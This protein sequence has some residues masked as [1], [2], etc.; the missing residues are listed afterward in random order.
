MLLWESTD[1]EMNM[2]D[3]Y[4]ICFPQFIQYMY[5]FIKS[6]AVWR[7]QDGYVGK[8]AASD[9]SATRTQCHST[10]FILVKSCAN[11]TRLLHN[12]HTPQFGVLPVYA[13]D[14]AYSG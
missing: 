8:S 10:V 14:V 1:L 2:I 4:I 9:L 3:S 12:K 5:Q 7:Q 13:G 11:D 6:A